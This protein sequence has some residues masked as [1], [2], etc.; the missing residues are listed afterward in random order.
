MDLVT[1][2]VEQAATPE[3]KAAPIALGVSLLPALAFFVFSPIVYDEFEY[4]RATRWIVNGRLPFRDFFEH[5]TP[6][7]WY[8]L[9]PVG[10]LAHGTGIPTFLALR[11]GTIALWVAT[12]AALFVLLRRKGA[13]SWATLLAFGLVAGSTTV[14]RNLVE[15]RLD[16]AMTLAFALAIVL[17][18]SSLAQE[19]R[20][21]TRLFGAGASLALGCLAV[22]RLAPVAVLT[23]LLYAVVRKGDHWGFR[24]RSA[25]IAL[26]AAAITAI[27]VSFFA[28]QGG[29]R[30]LVDQ[31]VTL[32]L[33]FEP[34]ARKSSFVESLGPWYPAFILQARDTPLLL[35]WAAGLAA[36]AG[37]IALLRRPV[38]AVRLMILAAAHLLVVARLPQMLPYQLLAVWWLLASLIAE[39]ATALPPAPTR[40][41]RRAGPAIVVIASL[42][43]SAG[44]DWTLLA[45]TQAY[46]SRTLA[47]AHALTRPDERILDGVGFAL[48]REPAQRFWFLPTLVVLLTKSGELPALDVRDLVAAKPAAIVFSRRLFLYLQECTSNSLRLFLSRSYLPLEPAIWIP[49]MSVRLPPGQAVP[50]AV[51]RSGSYRAVRAPALRDSPFFA[52]PFL[53]AFTHAPAEASRLDT[54]AL[55]ALARG[56]AVSLSSHGT[57]LEPAADGTLSLREGQ[58]LVAKNFGADVEVVLIVPVEHPVLF[59][60]PFPDLMWDDKV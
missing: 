8:L 13:P 4:A 55:P 33:H 48:D 49:A 38:F 18:E 54:R 11:A 6:L 3:S 34:L 40:L 35:L 60:Q 58:V 47:R 56:D 2:P 32:N 7:F 39:R 5:H 12:A 16:A 53:F 52:T 42:S 41:A 26:G 36:A 21:A 46:Q 45:R 9:A 27:T 10:A 19:R 23:T 31:A 17:L 24:V 51:L 25:W 57:A 20:E 22:Q 59:D 50:L 29:M 28:V 14:A 43:A 44:V 1:R 15:V 30:P 37:T